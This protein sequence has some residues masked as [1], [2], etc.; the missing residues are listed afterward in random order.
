[1]TTD[2]FKAQLAANGEWE[3][4]ISV[5]PNLVDMREWD[6]PEKSGRIGPVKIVWAGSL[7]HHGDLEIVAPACLEII[8][9]YKN[10]VQF[11]FMGMMPENLRANRNVEF[12]E[13]LRQNVVMFNG[14]D[15]NYYQ[16]CM[17]FIN[18][19]IALLPL[20]DNEF[21][22]AKSNIKYLEMTLSGAACIASKVGP[23]ADSIQK[24]KDGYLVLNKTEDWYTRMDLLVSFYDLRNTCNIYAMNKVIDYYTWD[25]QTKQTWINFFRKVAE[26]PVAKSPR[27]GD[28]AIPFG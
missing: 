14:V 7:T 22:D 10:K 17:N 16:S 26:T 24:N 28:N 6:F 18:P 5:N 27:S 15:I 20:E 11:V 1:V 13:L 21:N 9:K 23:Y 8:K 25:S 19:D 2:R 3:P 12:S 4:K